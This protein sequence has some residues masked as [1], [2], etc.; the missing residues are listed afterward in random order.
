MKAVKEEGGVVGH[1]RLVTNAPLQS[2][3]RPR[4][5][6]YGGGDGQKLRWRLSVAVGYNTTYRE[7]SLFPIQIENAS[8][9]NL[10]NILFIGNINLFLFYKKT[11]DSLI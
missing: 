6:N 7:P 11:I 3:L 1:Q 8:K 2:L 9:R 10:L 4:E 5:K